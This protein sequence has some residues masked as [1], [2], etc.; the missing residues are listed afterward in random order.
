V[1]KVHEVNKSF[2]SLNTAC[3]PKDKIKWPHTSSFKLSPSGQTQETLKYTGNI[4][5]LIYF[6]AGVY[7]HRATKFVT[8]APNICGPSV[9]NLLHV[10]LLAPR[11]LKWLLHFW[12]IYNWIFPIYI[13]FHIHVFCLAIATIRVLSFSTHVVC[14]EITSLISVDGRHS[15]AAVAR[16]V[17]GFVIIEVQTSGF[18]AVQLEVWHF[19]R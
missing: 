13:F 18:T 3:L 7:K 9:W 10:T 12:K 2:V 5:L 16:L 4:Y 15:A 17:R 6:K 14:I 1:R 8:V 11:I 19:L